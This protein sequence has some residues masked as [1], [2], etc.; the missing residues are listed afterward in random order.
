MDNDGRDER[1]RDARLGLVV[2]T[3]AREPENDIVFDFT[4]LHRPDLTDLALILTARLQSMP[5]DRV[6]VRA[7][8][9]GTWGILEA[10]GLDHL[11]RF[12]PGP[13]EDL[14]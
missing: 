13:E 5:A 9:P 7:L 11:F 3:E 8:P 12:Y 2:R 10:L 4:G 6:W 1:R 14:N